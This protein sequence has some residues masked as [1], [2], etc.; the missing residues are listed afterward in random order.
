MAE[1][2]LAK[3]D[4][5][6]WEVIFM[7]RMEVELCNIKLKN[8]LI[9]A[10]GTFGF[11]EEF[12]DYYDTKILGG[13]VSKG[14]TRIAKDGNK[15]VRIWESPSGILNSIGLENPGVEKF[16]TDYFPK[17]KKLGSEIFVN[18]GGNTLD[19][20]VEG[21]EI[22]EDLDFNFLELNV[23]C[24]N[25]SKGGMAF[26]LEAGPLIEVV[27]NVR[28]VTKKKLI[29]KLSPNARDM[30]EVARACQ[31]AGAD[32]VSLINTILGMAI[33]FDKRKNVFNNDYAGLSGP[34]VKPIAL[35]MVHQISRAIDIPIVAM[36]GVTSYK[37]VLEFLMVGASAVEVG[38]YNFMNPYGPKE[39]IEDLEKYLDEKN[40]FVKDFIGLIK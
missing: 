11:G 2:G 29:V 27:K 28:K 16:C 10:S 1:K 34:C 20:Y 25:V 35:R 19:E 24:P 7:N 5:Y 40:E 23:S 39:I 32:G 31:E 15:G 21:A 9:T 18:L 12:I 6:L 13:I 8:P 22:L 30:V 38:T 17:M 37:D 33:D 36:G 4:Q 26:G 3:M 14:I